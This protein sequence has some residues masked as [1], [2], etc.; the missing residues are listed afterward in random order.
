M[1]S[2]AR[3]ASAS[4]GLGGIAQRLFVALLV[5]APL[6]LGGN[7]PLAWHGFALVTGLCL[8]LLALDPKATPP[9]LVPPALH[10]MVVGGLV[11]CWITFQG[12]NG[13]PQGW[14]HP[15]WEGLEREMVG[16]APGRAIDSLV[17]AATAIGGFW[18]GLQ[19]GRSSRALAVLIIGNAAVAALAMAALIT[20]VPPALSWLNEAYPDDATGPFV[21]R[22]SFGAYAVIGLIMALGLTRHRLRAGGGPLIQRLDDSWWLAAAIALLAAAIVSSHSRGAWLSLIC[23]LI[24][25]WLPHWTGDRRKRG[26]YGP[27][28]VA[29]PL[30]LAVIAGVWLLLAST[31]TLVRFADG[32]WQGRFE[33]WQ[34]TWEMILAR[35]LLGHGAGAFAYLFPGFAGTRLTGWYDNPHNLYLTWA[36]AFGLPMAALCVGVAFLAVVG[37]L[38]ARPV[39]AEAALDLAIA[40]GALVAAAVHSLMDNAYETPAISLLIAW[41]TGRAMRALGRAPPGAP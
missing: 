41:L 3:S 25:F 40:R 4:T 16:A 32:G 8:L 17:L 14:A 12:L 9:R 6:P 36:A 33:I 19:K 34:I 31:A 1:P 2:H 29:F 24:A 26:P 27:A 5:L 38:R 23:A 20:P 13:L 28:P 35:P 11:L 10:V 37:V 18:M 22:N 7:E 15:A 30:F 39:S 21:S